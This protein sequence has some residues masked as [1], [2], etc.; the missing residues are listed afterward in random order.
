MRF[1]L[2]LLVPMLALLLAPDYTSAHGFAD[3]RY[4]PATFAV[5]D[6]FVSDEAGILVG[7][8]K[9]PNGD[10]TSTNTTTDIGLNYAKT[11]IPRFAV[12]LGMDDLHLAPDGV[13]RANGFATSVVGGKHLAYINEASEA[14]PSVGANLELGGTGTV[15]AG[16]N[17]GST[18]SPFAPVSA[19]A[20]PD[21]QNDRQL[22][23]QFTH[24]TQWHPAFTSPYSGANSLSG[25]NDS[26]ETT[27]LTLIAGL[28]LSS[29]SEIWANPE[30]DQG[31]GLNNTLGVAGFPSGEALKV[32]ANAPYLRL[33]RLFYR[34]VTNLG[35]A[36]QTIAPGPNQM[37]GTR[38]ADNV[39][40][41]LG[42][43]SAVDVFDTNTYAH[44]PRA[45]FMNWSIVESGA[46]DYAADA[47]GYSYGASLEWTQSWWTARGGL[48]AL[49]KIPNGKVL[50][51]EFKQREWVGELEERHQLGGRPGKLKVLAYVNQGLMGSYVEAVQL[52]Q[53]TN[54]TPDT[55]LVRR[56][57]SS[58]G[59][60]LNF[61]QEVSPTLGTFARASMNNGSKEVFEFTEINQSVA[62]G[63]SAHGDNW[64]RR[65][66][67]F[68][69]A[70][71][72]NGLSGAAR[73][74][75]AAGGIGVLIGDGKLP[76]Y[77]LEN[78]VETYYSYALSTADRLV[79]TLDYQHINNP[80]YNRDR[81][82]V[83]IFGVRLHAEF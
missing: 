22:K 17:S 52:A 27:D 23:G 38:T 70:G 51:P 60:A 41:T 34:N 73:R 65:D 9:T 20:T 55:G 67:T 53:Q 59:G 40:L 44:D 45:D 18:L 74:Y 33:P 39:I 76:H 4:F 68:G 58:A 36:E 29:S 64:G 7:S 48:F 71:V 14:L 6:P 46:Y 25:A 75:F 2:M 69:L 42:K 61:E 11:F 43:F 47:W 72:A 12:S 19:V 8:R 5:D 21:T 57:S 13:P 82:P 3:K 80:A 54:G 16:T 1:S 81:G 37:G 10:G 66:D 28:R 30:I 35:G 26:N 79:L 32:G 31:F 63:L 77:G 24:I 49:S 62:A 56:G 83:S 50:D 78:I 15:R